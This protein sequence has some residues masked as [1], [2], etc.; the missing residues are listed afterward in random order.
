MAENTALALAGNDKLRTIMRSPETT[1]R[2][3][4]VLGKSNA[5]AYI[6]SVLLAVANSEQLQKCSPA[7]IIT[8]AMR[9]ATLRL[10][11]DPSTKQA[12][13]VP[14]NTKIKG[15]NGEPDRWENVATLVVGHKGYYDMAN[16]TGRYHYLNDFRVFEGQEV[17][18]DQL[19][20]TIELRGQ[21]TSQKVIGYGFYFE[22][23]NGLK[24]VL[25]MTVEEIQEHGAKYS[26]TYNYSSSLWKTNFEAMA[27]KTVTRL[28]LSRYG[29]LDPT[30]ALTLGAVDEAELDD[31]DLMQIQAPPRQRRSYSQTMR[32]LGFEPDEPEPTHRAN[33]DMSTGELL[34]PVEGKFEVEFTKGISEKE[35]DEQR[36]AQE[37][38]EDE[39]ENALDDP[40]PADPYADLKTMAE[41]D[42]ATAFWKLQTR[43]GWNRNEAQAIVKECKADMTKAFAALLKNAPPAMI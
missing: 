42:A 21:R 26:K 41:T 36:R 2:F 20:G 38:L 15:K 43:I 29:Y 9:A 18:E 1:E 12:H 28:C 3:I 39:E 33:V 17:V 25:Y 35:L 7:S 14:F 6:T 19:R 31:N 23:T 34:E 10:S 22:M 30:D 24:K 37:A 11:C 32:E 4:E 40:Q 13:L 16:R 27:R 5:P 8:S